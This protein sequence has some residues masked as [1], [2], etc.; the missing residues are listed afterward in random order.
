[1]AKSD[2]AARPIFHHKRDAIQAHLTVV[3]TALA[4]SSYLHDRTGM[5]I[6]RL[7]Q[8]LRPLRTVKINIAGQQ[9]TVQPRVDAD[10]ASILDKIADL[11]GPAANAFPTRSNVVCADV[12]CSSTTTA[13]WCPAYRRP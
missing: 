10:T 6:K 1:M 5:T 2:L 4:V 12:G 8:T 13:R 7:V 11:K 9:L 3:F